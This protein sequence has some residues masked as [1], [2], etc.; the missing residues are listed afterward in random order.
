MPGCSRDFTGGMVNGA[1]PAYNVEEMAYALKIAKS[2]VLLT[3]P[4]TLGVAVA[5]AESV[6]LPKTHIILLE[7]EAEGFTSIQQL[8][9]V[10]KN[11]TADPPYRIPKGQT[12]GEVCGYLNFSSGT[13]GLPKAVMLSHQNLI[14]Q[15][16]QLKQ[17]QLGTGPYRVLAVMPLFH[18][19]SRTPGEI[20]RHV[21]GL[22]Q[23]PAWLDSVTTQCL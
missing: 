2:K 20:G 4:G 22:S 16:M 12:N 7:G 6:G 10:G 13:T 3:L 19:K 17:L 1:S 21:N 23:S 15:C 5:A 14:A 18:S 11:Y 8:V 9:E